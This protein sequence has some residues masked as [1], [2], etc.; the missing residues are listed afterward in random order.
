MENESKIGCKDKKRKSENFIDLVDDDIIVKC[1]KK[2]R[3]SIDISGD[4]NSC[5]DDHIVGKE[6]EY[7]IIRLD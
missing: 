2:T 7:H 3:V 6:G 4:S 1:G 5:E